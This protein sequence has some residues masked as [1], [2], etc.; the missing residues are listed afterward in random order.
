MNNFL[1]TT[2]VLVAFKTMHI[3]AKKGKSGKV[4]QMVLK[5]DMSKAQIGSNGDIWKELC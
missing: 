2:N 5:L 4:G 1:I 3:L